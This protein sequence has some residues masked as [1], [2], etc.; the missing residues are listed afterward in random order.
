MAVVA[1]TLRSRSIEEPRVRGDAAEPEPIF[2]YITVA[3]AVV[4]YGFRSA[5]EHVV[6]MPLEVV[7]RWGHFNAIGCPHLSAMEA[8]IVAAVLELV[9]NPAADLKATFARYCHVPT[10]EEGMQ[11]APKEKAIPWIMRPILA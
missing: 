8:V 5:P 10:V 3:R 4:P 6:S 7:L 11:A 2:S 9:A 1:R